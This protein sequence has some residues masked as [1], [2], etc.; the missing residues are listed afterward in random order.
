MGNEQ[1]VHRVNAN[2][3]KDKLT[4]RSKYLRHST[5]SEAR[6]SREI[7]FE[8]CYKDAVWQQSIAKSNKSKYLK[9]H[10]LQYNYT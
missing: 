7:K 6:Q 2:P 3:L 1:T 8:V 4:I 9:P 5:K 10:N